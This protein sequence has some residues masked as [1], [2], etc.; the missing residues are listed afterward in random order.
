VLKTRILSALKKA[1][2]E[3][4]GLFGDGLKKFRGG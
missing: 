1:K 3:E 4:F 2:E